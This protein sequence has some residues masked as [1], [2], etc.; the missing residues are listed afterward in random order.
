MESIRNFLNRLLPKGSAMRHVSI[1]AGGT[2]VAQGLGIA[3]MPIIS[4][5]YSPADFGVM[6]VFASVTAILTEL[7][8]FR[9]H[10]AIPL[11]KQDRYAKAL[12]VLSFLL[13]AIFVVFISIGILVLGKTILSK[14]SMG[15]LIPYR[16]LIPVGV[17]GMGAYLALTQWA[18][19]E[20]LF[21]TIARTKVTQSV[22]GILTK[23]ILGLLGL[24]PLGLLLGSIASQAGG[25]TTLARSII[26]KKGISKPPKE[27]IKRVASRYR[28]FPMFETWSGMLN[29]VGRQIMPI[30]LVG[31]YNTQVAGLFA[32]AQNLLLIPAV[33]IGQAIGQVFLQRASVARHE[34][35]LKVLSLRT[36]TLLLRLGFFPILLI[37]FFA[38]PIFSFVLGPRWL[39]AGSFAMVLGPWIAFGF[40]YSPMSVLFAILDRQGVGLAT[41][42]LYITGRVVAFWVGS[43]YGGPILAASLFGGLGFVVLLSRANYLL[44]VAGNDRRQL[45]KTNVAIFLET[46]FLLVLPLGALIMNL[47][48]VLVSS[49]LAIA[50]MVY[51]ARGYVIFLKHGVTK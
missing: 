26:K 36:Y 42:I 1:L 46:I 49:A 32:M 5:I 20:K 44:L 4:R 10:L 34:G 8:G 19:R 40:A 45:F 3:V 28:K 18:I 6:A 38:P 47:G 11:P 12:V 48:L 21:Q 27:D 13:Q 51:L 7:S 29:T 9:Y 24:K 37:S 2:A 14:I 39:E 43:L 23:V 31:F 25:I 30:M 15:V 16:Y 17:A 35:N 22:S 33:F 50:V 41:E